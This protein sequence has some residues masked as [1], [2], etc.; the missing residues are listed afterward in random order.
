MK[1][2]NI[3][4]VIVVLAVLV[5][6]GWLLVSRDSKT[7]VVTPAPAVPAMEVSVEPMVLPAE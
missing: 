4:S 7:V 5:A 6:I 1:H 2:Q 3:I